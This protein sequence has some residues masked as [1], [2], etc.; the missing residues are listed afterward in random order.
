MDEL[1][2]ITDDFIQSEYMPNYAKKQWT[3]FYT[4]KKI[5]A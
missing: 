5:K 3:L 2:Q 4:G 1:P